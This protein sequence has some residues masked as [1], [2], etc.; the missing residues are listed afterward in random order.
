MKVDHHKIQAIL[1]GARCFRVPL[2]QRKYQWEEKHLSSFWEDV[3]AKAAEVLDKDTKFEHYMGAL[4]LSPLESGIEVTP[5]DQV[6]DGQQRLTTFQIFLSALREVARQ[7]NEQEI[8]KQVKCYLEN[9]RQNKDKDPLTQFKL[10]PTSSDR[11]LIH[12]IIRLPFEEADRK[13]KDLYHGSRVPKSSHEPAFLAY[14][15]FR[16]WIG[17]FVRHGPQDFEV[18]VEVD[19]VVPEEKDTE[20]LDKHCVGMRLDA[21]LT[22]LL[23]R[24]KLVVITLGENDDAQV[25]FE[26]LNS[27]GKPLLAMDL[28][29]N[30]IFYRAERKKLPVEEL[31][32]E[33][34]RPL[35]KPWW[36]DPAPNARPRRPRIDHFLAHVIVAESGRKISIH[37]LYAKYREFAVPKSKPRFPNVENELKLLERYAP[38]YL[39]LEGKEEN[40][41]G[42]LTW[43]GIK[44]STWQVTTIYPVALQM[45][46][47]EVDEAE[48]L[49]IAHLLYSYLVRREICGLTMKNMNNISQSLAAH[50]LSEGISV[51]SLK[52]FF[53]DRMDSDSSKFP[54]DQEFRD[55]FLSRNAYSIHPTS[56]LVDIL[57]ELETV[58][59]SKKSEKFSQ[60]EGLWVEHVLPQTWTDEWPF[61]D[62]STGQL[63]NDDQKSRDRNLV[64]NVFGNLSL[65]T[66]KLNGAVSNKSFAVK[67]EE[68]DKH[69]MLYL[70]RW[71]VGYEQWTEREIKARG[72]H[73]AN[74]AVK[75]WGGL[76]SSP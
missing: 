49:R 20:V 63:D 4:I 27:Q 11:K 61:Q 70:N 56:R 42:A 53:N 25:I 21:L 29:R 32:E 73:L 33:Y 26:T 17:E 31:Y 5:V 62:G 7:H 3:S 28:V 45:G 22:A 59:R 41:S 24:I 30:N 13:Y 54:S 51:D 69:T 76:E 55:G 43:L 39:T 75:H 10:I 60:P 12:D 1:K 68:F 48:R 66:S 72:N 64:V 2:Y 36:R 6:V 46:K 23:E 9:P 52:R 47:E 71:I 16:K 14:F 19:P 57:W 58:S 18:P 65:L 8:V 67:R 15:L 34:W 40:G 74:L 44:L 35:D 38:I 37:D 50:F